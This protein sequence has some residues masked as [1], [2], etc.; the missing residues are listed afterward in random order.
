M[1]PHHFVSLQGHA[2]YSL[3]HFQAAKLRLFFLTAKCFAMFFH[4]KP[5][6][7]CKKNNLSRFV[8]HTLNQ[9]SPARSGKVKGNNSIAQGK[10]SDTLGF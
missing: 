2:H 6:V 8:Q 4:K 10:R 5:I 3:F 1:L 9:R 7:M